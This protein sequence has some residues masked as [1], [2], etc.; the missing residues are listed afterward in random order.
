MHCYFE[1]CWTRLQIDRHRNL[2][3]TTPRR[4]LAALA[5]PNA[6]TIRRPAPMLT[7]TMRGCAVGALVPFADLF[8]HAPGAG[9]DAPHIGGAY[10]QEFVVCAC[11][12]AGVL[13]HKLHA[14][15]VLC[16]VCVCATAPWTCCRQAQAN[17]DFAKPHACTGLDAVLQTT[18]PTGS[19]HTAGQAL[20][21]RCIL[22]CHP[23]W[24][25][26]MLAEMY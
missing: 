17:H 15:W 3:T 10:F 4:P 1:L 19:K 12:S 21:L 16:G 13:M 14:C 18:C 6:S 24:F 2:N 25:F 20:L 23:C 5:C 26:Q 7:N 11:S 8:N 9:P 22:A